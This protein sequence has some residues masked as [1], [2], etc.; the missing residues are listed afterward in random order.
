M[1]CI[2]PEFI[3]KSGRRFFVPCGKCNYC[4]ETKR[5]D[6]SFRLNQEQKV[7]VS[8]KF[9]TLTYDDVHVNND[10]PGCVRVSRDGYPQLCE[11]DLQ[12]FTKRLRKANAEINDYSLRYYSVGE[13]G[14]RTFRP[15]YHSIMF[16]LH[17]NLFMKVTDIWGLGMC[18]VDECEPASIHYVTKYVINRVT[19]AQGRTSPFAFMSKRPGLG[20]N[21]LATHTQ[22]HRAAMRNYTEVNGQKSRIPRFY[23]NR[24]FTD[25]ERETLASEALYQSDISYSDTV[26]ENFRFHSDP[27]YYQDEQVRSR[28]DQITSKINSL[29]TF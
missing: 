27:Y 24:L 17:P 18:R 21:Y 19:D 12:L 11:R 28:H 6:W 7:S 20:V 16:N 22:W 3:R 10:T 25:R 13:Y 9:L 26:T 5:A 4:L 14:T 8:A 1:Q 15:H 29:N 2:S 23:K